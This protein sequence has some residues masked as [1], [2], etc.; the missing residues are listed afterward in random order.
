MD[1]PYLLVMISSY[2]FSIPFHAKGSG[3]NLLNKWNSTFAPD[4]LR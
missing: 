1:P 2:F 4:I 3:K